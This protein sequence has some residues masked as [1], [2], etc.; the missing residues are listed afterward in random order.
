MSPDSLSTKFGCQP[1]QQ[2]RFKFPKFKAQKLSIVGRELEQV[3]YI[4][5]NLESRNQGDKILL[6]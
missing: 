5:Y 4:A 2:R 6:L 3:G 1:Q